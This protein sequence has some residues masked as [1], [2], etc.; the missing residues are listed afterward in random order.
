MGEGGLGVQAIQLE[1]GQVRLFRREL[2][3]GLGQLGAGLPVARLGTLGQAT[4]PRHG[5]AHRGH[6]LG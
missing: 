3:P 6:H 4:R 2:A 5:G 1:G